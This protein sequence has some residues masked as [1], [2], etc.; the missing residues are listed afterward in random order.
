MDELRELRTKIL[1]LTKRNHE[2]N[3]QA[4]VLEHMSTYHVIMK[5]ICYYYKLLCLNMCHIIMKPI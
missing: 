1:S 4:T 2:N 3:M 5:T